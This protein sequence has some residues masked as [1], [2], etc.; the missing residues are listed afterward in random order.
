M[1]WQS[2][3]HNNV[4]MQNRF[5]VAKLGRFFLYLGRDLLTWSGVYCSWCGRDCGFDSTYSKKGL[6]CNSLNRDCTKE[7]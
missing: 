7:P 4:W 6:R 1:S 5:W 2:F 3:K